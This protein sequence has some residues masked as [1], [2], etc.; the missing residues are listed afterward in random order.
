MTQRPKSCS[1]TVPG[2]YLL[3][4]VFLIVGLIALLL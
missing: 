3:G 2:V 4:L 1:C